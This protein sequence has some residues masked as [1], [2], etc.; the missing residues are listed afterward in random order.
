MNPIHTADPP[1]LR[2]A[3]YTL[4]TAKVVPDAALLDDMV[5]RYPQFS[6]EL[7][8]YAIAIAIDALRGDAAV[9]AAESARDAMVMSPTVSR[10]M[11]RFQN[12]LHAMSDQGDARTTA[13]RPS[14]ADA[15]NPFAALSRDEFRAFAKR[16]DANSVFVAKLRDRQIDPTTLTPGFHQR[17]ADDLRAPLGVVVAHF[18]A[19]QGVAARPQFYKADGKPTNGGRQR[20]EEA[21]ESSG[22]SEA[23]QRALLAL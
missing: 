15:P 2:D 18:A 6:G 13:P 12:R 3:L 20:F 16:L 14:G 10:A 21:V 23:Q 9:E 7:T 19:M 4:A 1:G 8:D 5:R 11:S 17:V 22:L